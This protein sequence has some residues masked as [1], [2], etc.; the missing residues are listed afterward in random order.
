[1]VQST[2][3][4]E[5]KANIIVNGLLFSFSGTSLGNLYQNPS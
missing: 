4:G 3:G 2:A 1:M 5:K